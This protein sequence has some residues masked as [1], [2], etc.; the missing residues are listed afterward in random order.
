[1]DHYRYPRKRKVLEEPD[2]KSEGNNP[3]CGDEVSFY[4]ML[5]SS[6]VITDLSFMGKGCV[7]SQAAASML[8]EACEGALAKEVLA[9]DAA[10]MKELLGV[11][12]GPVRLKCGL[13]ALE[14]L[15]KALLSKT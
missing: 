10:Y 7:I 14:V 9:H 13:L 12:L 8:V 15:Q 2:L 1:M 11:P 3:S 6:G 4:V 5:S